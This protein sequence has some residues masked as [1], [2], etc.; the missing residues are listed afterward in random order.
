MTGGKPIAVLQSIS[1]VYLINPLVAFYDIYGGK[2]QVLFFYFVPYTTRD[3]PTFYKMWS[4]VSLGLKLMLSLSFAK[5]V[6]VTA[7]VLNKDQTRH[8]KSQNNY[9][10]IINL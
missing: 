3:F 1:S 6:T 7:S 2:R 8:E 10:I 5:R 9:K 4:T